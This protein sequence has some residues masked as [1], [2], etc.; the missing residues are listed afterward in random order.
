MSV[1]FFNSAGTDL[2]NLFYVNNP[3]AG[4]IGFINAS[5]QDLGNRYTNAS[6]LG[7]AVGFRNSAGTDLGYLRGNGVPAAITG[8]GASIV[9]TYGN[10]NSKTDNTSGGD[11]DYYI[12]TYHRRNV[13]VYLNC[14]L[15][16][17][18]NGTTV[19]QV[20]ICALAGSHALDNIRLAVWDNQALGSG[21]WDIWKNYTNYTHGAVSANSEG[22]HI[23]VTSNNCNLRPGRKF[24]I[25]LTGSW[26]DKARG[27]NT[28][29]P[30]GV[31]IFQHFYNNFGDP[32]WVSKDIWFG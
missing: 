15:T 25:H 19:H 4:G 28:N 21:N 9:T 18:G 17:A 26:T 5:G 1:N 20:D 7:Y 11:N 12:D 30:L 10:I 32:G 24:T 14:W 31:R 3:N 8:H 29:V 2:D 6:T 16:G 22:T 23:R 13:G 27:Q